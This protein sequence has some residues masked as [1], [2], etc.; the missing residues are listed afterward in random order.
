MISGG[1]IKAAKTNDIKNAYLLLLERFL[2]LI[3]PILDKKN[4]IIGI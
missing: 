4:A 3:N 2:E 1:V